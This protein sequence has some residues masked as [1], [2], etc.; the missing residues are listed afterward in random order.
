MKL[1]SRMIAG[2]EEK[3]HSVNFRFRFRLSIFL[4]C[5]SRSCQTLIKFESVKNLTQIDLVTFR[6]SQV[7]MTTLHSHWSR[8]NPHSFSITLT[9]FHF[10]LEVE[11]R[12]N[13]CTE[14]PGLNSEK[15]SGPRVSTEALCVGQLY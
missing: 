6:L 9:Y 3:V 11:K 1:I 13:L 7:L 2:G 10:P 14:K 4:S 12:L 15:I 8:V 5:S